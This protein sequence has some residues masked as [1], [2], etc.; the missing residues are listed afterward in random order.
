MP[1]LLA[2]SHEATGEFLQDETHTTAPVAGLQ[3]YAG[4]L[5]DSGVGR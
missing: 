4:H 3:P 1:K 2:E 5:L